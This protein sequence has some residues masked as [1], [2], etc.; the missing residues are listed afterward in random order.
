VF[1]HILFLSSTI[2]ELARILRPGGRVYAVFP[3]GSAIIEQ[4]CGLPWIHALESR[5]MRL[6]YIKV[7]KLLGFYSNPASP[8]SMESYIYSNVFYRRENE[9]RQLFETNFN[10]VESDT[11][12]YIN[13][14]ADSLLLQGGMKA[15][16]GKF[17]KANVDRLAAW[18]HLRHSAAY[19]LSG[20][21]KST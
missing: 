15:L 17:L 16:M 12:T 10:E 8:S 11:R 5:K 7:A 18:V 1:E 4:H 6:S 14:K 3:L 2:R 19:C 20:P 13:I 21:R 9:I